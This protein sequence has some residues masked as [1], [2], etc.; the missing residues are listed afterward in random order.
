MKNIKL[1]LAY[2]GTDFHGW[3]IQ[4]G[5]Q[6]IQ[7]AIAEVAER[8]VGCHT[9]VQGAGRTD[10]GVHA[11][12]QVANF[13]AHTRLTPPEFQRAFNALLPPAIRVMD[14]E[15]VEPRFHSRWDAVGK[16]Y[17][18]RIF[19]GRVIG[20]FDRLYALHYPFPL[21]EDAMAEAARLFEGE[22]DFSSFAASPGHEPGGKEVNPRREIFRSE[23]VRRPSPSFALAA[24]V[25]GL[26][27]RLAAGQPGDELVYV[28]RGKSFLRYMVRKL[29]GTLLEVGRGRLSLDQVR[30]L[31]EL[32]DRSRSGPTAPPQGL[33]LVSVD[34]PEPWRIEA[35]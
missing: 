21:D 35:G 14:A 31:F 33:S 16:T 28:V 24:T 25:E 11:L 27:T 12:G 8:L 20:P 29:V 9:N 18:Y 32:H 22:H 23:L 34:Y 5:R 3:Q 10:A 2:D 26:A 1:T 17:Q 7:G 13:R 6:T 4:P 19:R 15:E 30:E